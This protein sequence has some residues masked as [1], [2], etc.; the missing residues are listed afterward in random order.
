M[1]EKDFGIC[2]VG[3]AKTLS[4]DVLPDPDPDRDRDRIQNVSVGLLS[5]PHPHW[6]QGGLVISLEICQS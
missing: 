2:P 5:V 1:D 3:H 4:V 6:T